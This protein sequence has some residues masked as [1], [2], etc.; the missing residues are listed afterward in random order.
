M[1]FYPGALSAVLLYYY[2]YYQLAHVDFGL[3]GGL[4]VTW[5]L[6]I[7]EQ[8]Y[9][10]FPLVFKLFA[11]KNVINQRRLWALTAVCFLVLLWRFVLV[12]LVHPTKVDDWA[13]SATDARF[14][15]ILWGCILAIASNPLRE[16]DVYFRFLDVHKAALAVTGLGV[17]VGCLV[18]RNELFRNTLRYTL[19]P[20][21][22]YP[23]FFYCIRSPASLIGRTLATRFLREIGHLS[24]TMYLIHFALLLVLS[25]RL[26]NRLL[27]A[28]VA[29]ALTACFAL[30]M[31]LVVED[32][33]R[34]VFR[35]AEIR[36]E[37]VSS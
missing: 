18:C 16:S 33:L 5:S 29:F 20:M 15:S 12:A 14:D 37:L 8:F 3:P 31:R 34:R 4:D 35:S 17:I 32:P 2:N 19:L 7:E 28:I 30:L 26:H 6:M 36:P 25:R 21:S 10:L 22:L 24:Y 11:V 27:S 9:L 23:I 13:Y 1:R